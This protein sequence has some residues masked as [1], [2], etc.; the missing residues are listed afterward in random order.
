[1]SLKIGDI[2]V[3]NEIIEL[4]FQ[5]IRTQLLLEEVMK[6]NKLN[7]PNQSQIQ[8]IE[9]RAINLLNQKFPNMGIA[10]KKQ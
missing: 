6:L 4:H 5:V 10:K 3:A 9:E 1:M 7:Y 2:E 8:Q